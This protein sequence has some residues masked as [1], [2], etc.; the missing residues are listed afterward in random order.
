MYCRPVPSRSPAP[1]RPRPARP[2]AAAGERRIMHA[3]RWD[4]CLGPS[5]AIVP[6]SAA[7]ASIY[8][9][10]I[11]LPSPLFL[12]LP[13]AVAMP[14]ISQARAGETPGAASGA[15]DAE[16]EAAGRGRRPMRHACNALACMVGP[17]LGDCPPLSLWSS[18]L[19][20]LSPPSLSPS[21]SPCPMY[22]RPMLARRRG[23]PPLTRPRAAAGGG[24]ITHAP[25][26]HACSGPCCDCPVSEQPALAPL[27]LALSPRA[28]RRG[29]GATPA[30]PW[31]PARCRTRAGRAG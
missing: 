29:R 9:S 27:S 30:G 14:D 25:R 6:P 15:V 10:Q 11:S 3:P 20:L 4:P 8:L 31:S 28:P 21:R 16:E 1:A 12:S 5:S 19:S 22:G 2:P 23:L 17:F 26:S 24:C 7:A 13:R 18:E